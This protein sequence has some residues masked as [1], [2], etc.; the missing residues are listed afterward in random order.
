MPPI[1][2]LVMIHGMSPE[3]EPH[4]PFDSQGKFW[5]YNEFWANLCQEQPDLPNLFPQSFIGVEWGHELPQ[6]SLPSVE[7]LREDQRLT[8][9]QNF[10]NQR[11]AYDNLVKAPNDNNVT[12]SLFS[13]R[14]ADIPLLTPMVRALVVGLR[15]S[16]VTRGL[17]DVIYYTSE[18]G[19]CYVRQT[20]YHQVLKK[21]AQYEQEQDVRIHLIGQSLGVTLTHDFLYGLFAPNHEPGFYKQASEE[22]KERFKTWRQKRQNGQLKLGSLTSTASQLPLFMMRTQKLVDRLAKGELIDAK[23][24]GIDNSNQIQWQLFYDI[25]DLLGFG[26]RRLY[27]AANAIK[28]YQVDTGDNPGDAHTGYWQNRMVIEQ[29]AQLLYDNASR[30]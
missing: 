21:L 19:E 3:P 6:P 27:N 29:T 22:D 1:N 5:G 15:E 11:I 25:D 7:Q 28:E 12:L 16:I 2:V 18:Q 8:R 9:A 13:G 14:G 17:G 30:P 24:I 26:T 23:D 20:V 4:S 10:V